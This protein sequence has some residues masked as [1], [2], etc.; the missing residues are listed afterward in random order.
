M[1]LPIRGRTEPPAGLL[2]RI[3][4]MLRSAFPTLVTLGLI[5]LAAVP[6]GAPGL[7]MA[8]CLPTVF[9]WTI[10][11]P[12]TMPPPAVFCIGLTQDLLTL[13]PLGSGVLLLLLTH[14]IIMRFRGLLVR[15]SFWLV[16]L[17]YAG[18]AVG[19]AAMVWALTGLLNWQ[20]PP[21]TP[22]M[23]QLGISVG[24]YPMLAWVLTRAHRAMQNAEA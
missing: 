1:K 9:F 21:T 22:A 5:V 17:V 8:V 20:L 3:D 11:R 14:G 15:Q 19:G 10:F 13:A 12:S 23:H 4:A 24:L 18:V 16:W 2:R 7:I 6:V